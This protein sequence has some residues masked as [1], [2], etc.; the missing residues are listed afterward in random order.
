MRIST[1]IRL[2]FFLRGGV[3]GGSFGGEPCPVLNVLWL[4]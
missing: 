1:L 2:D 3:G 4:R